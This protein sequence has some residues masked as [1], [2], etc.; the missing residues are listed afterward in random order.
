MSWL[1]GWD[2]SSVTRDGHG[3]CRVTV[4]R[5]LSFFAKHCRSRGLSSKQVHGRYDD[6]AGRV[7]LIPMKQE[8]ISQDT[9]GAEGHVAIGRLNPGQKQR[10]RFVFNAPAHISWPVL[11]EQVEGLRS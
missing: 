4:R 5:G 8:G 3:Y 1:G 2:L 9:V 11:D 6:L 7:D 10:R